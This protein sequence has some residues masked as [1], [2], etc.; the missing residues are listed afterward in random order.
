M[1]DA[2]H[3]SN[4]NTLPVK[5]GNVRVLQK[6]KGETSGE[7]VQE[8]GMSYTLLA[9]CCISGHVRPGAVTHIIVLRH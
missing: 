7:Y 5:G 6:R 9:L 2:M 1:V 3:S 4:T 8:E